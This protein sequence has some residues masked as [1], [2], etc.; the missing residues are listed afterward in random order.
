VGGGHEKE[1]KKKERKGE[2]KKERSKVEQPQRARKGV[3]DRG[4]VI[5]T[6]DSAMSSDVR[7]AQ[8]L[9]RRE[10]SE[11]DG[12]WHQGGKEER[13]RAQRSMC[14]TFIGAFAHVLYVQLVPYV[15]PA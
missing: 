12:V 9:C 14:C 5:T 11:E 7:S 13:K 15:L 3:W 4:S 1:R 6:M 10:G 8:S 2:R